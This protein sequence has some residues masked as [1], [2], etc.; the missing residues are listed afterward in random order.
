MQHLK[1]V[2]AAVAA[3]SMMWLAP[4][5]LGHGES[6]HGKPKAV[7]YS[8]A[9]ET[10]FGRAGNPKKADRTIRIGMNDTMHFT[11][12]A[13]ARPERTTDVRMGDGRHAM[14]GDIVIKRGETVRFVV[15]ND[16]KLMHE[17]VIGTMKELRDHAELMKRFPGMEHDEPYMAHVAPGKEGEIVWQ[18]TR[19]GEFHYACLVPGHM[20]AGMIA[21]ITVK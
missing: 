9:E 16:G 14:A 19:P 1:P 4:A 8:K 5:A 10:P 11:A 21:R 2:L 12:G 7:D 13:S 6:G 15:R 3:A 17:M 18:F 20:E